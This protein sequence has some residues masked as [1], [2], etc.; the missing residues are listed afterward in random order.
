[1]QFKK[2]QIWVF[3]VDDIRIEELITKVDNKKNIY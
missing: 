3:W 1:M 2:G